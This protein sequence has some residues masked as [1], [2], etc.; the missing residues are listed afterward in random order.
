MWLRINNSHATDSVPECFIFLFFLN[1]IVVCDFFFKKSN[2]QKYKRKRSRL[3]FLGGIRRKEVETKE[4]G[5]RQ[6]AT[7][8]GRTRKE[9]PPLAGDNLCVHLLSLCA[10]ELD[11]EGGPEYWQASPIWTGGQTFCF[12]LDFGCE[13]AA[14]G[15]GAS[16]PHWGPQALTTW[17]QRHVGT[18]I[19]YVRLW[20]LIWFDLIFEIFTWT[21]QSIRRELN[22]DGGRLV[23]VIYQGQMSPC[24][25]TALLWCSAVA[26]PNSRQTTG[27][28]VGLAQ[29]RFIFFIFVFFF[30]FFIP[31]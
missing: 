14:V 30:L 5:S 8:L 20:F 13:G 6:G 3:R 7:P 9:G 23:Q 17:E 11:R 31:A 26:P 16:L 10:R 4:G 15:A 25:C 29:F 19:V 24:D 28:D 27:A 1:F 2:R 12:S 21:F 18:P 22:G